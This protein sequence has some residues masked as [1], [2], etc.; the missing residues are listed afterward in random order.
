MDA[1]AALDALRGE[2]DREALAMP[3]LP[4]VAA[5][6]IASSVDEHSDAAR[7]AELIRQDQSLASHV[8]RI[9]NSPAFRGASEIV[10]L[11]QAIAR[12]GMP[13]VRR[14]PCPPR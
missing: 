12:L 9:V 14:S 4:G 6:V 7:L 10:A 8:L 1:A 2:L 3:L 5:E 13:R 11:Q